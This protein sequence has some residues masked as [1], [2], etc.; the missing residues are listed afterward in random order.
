MRYFL[1]TGIPIANCIDNANCQC[2]Q[3]GI[4]TGIGIALAVEL[5][6][7]CSVHGA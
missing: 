3:Q 4:G 6:K 7:K 5:R 1:A 2:S